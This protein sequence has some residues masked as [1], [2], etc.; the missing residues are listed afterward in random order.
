MVK[1][2][3]DVAPG[4]CAAQINSPS[5][6]S[7]RGYQE[8]HRETNARTRTHS[9]FILQ[10]TI[11][12]PYMKPFGG[13]PIYAA[14]GLSLTDSCGYKITIHPREAGITHSQ[15]VVLFGQSIVKLGGV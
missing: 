15:P 8:D 11:R 14:E 10:S 4:P 1:L 12:H 9:Q 2:A 13:S 7:V 5:T 3:A 6:A